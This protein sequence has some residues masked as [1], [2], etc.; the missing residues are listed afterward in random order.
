TF[1]F[2]GLR[3]RGGLLQFKCGSEVFEIE[4]IIDFVRFGTNLQRIHAPRTNPT[5]GVGQSVIS[6]S[7]RREPPTETPVHHLPIMASGKP[8]RR[9]Q[10]GP[11]PPPTGR[12]R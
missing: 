6:R 5:V 8:P 11:P 10:R 2:Q 4:I 12:P 1:I 3:S 7:W 9:R